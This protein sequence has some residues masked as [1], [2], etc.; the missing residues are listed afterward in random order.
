MRIDQRQ[1]RLTVLAIS[2]VALFAADKLAY[3]PLAS[4]WRGRSQQ[5]E[6]LRRRVAEGS[7]LLD[8]GPV[9]RRRWEQMRSRTL[10]DNASI[11]EQRLLKAFDSWSRES[12]VGITAIT[13]QWK[14]DAD[15][16]MTLECRVD[17]TGSLEA[18]RRF[19]YAAEKDPLALKIQSV[20]LA[21]RDNS[22]QQMALGLQLSGLILT[23]P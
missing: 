12:R 16:H 5:I 18:V 14:Q 19:L 15:D 4:A 23:T 22:G 20:E 21:A 1:R 11:A 6:E 8:R 2:V 13:P 9:L 7:S 3:T 17:A 10:P